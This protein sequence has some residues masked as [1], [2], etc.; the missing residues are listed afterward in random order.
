MIERLKSAIMND[1]VF[2]TFLNPQ[3][4]ITC[5]TPSLS[6]IPILLLLFFQCSLLHPQLAFNQNLRL[7]RLILTPINFWSSLKISIDYCFKPL[8][9]S[10][11]F[12]FFFSCFGIHLSLKSLEWGLADDHQLK[13]IHQIRHEFDLDDDDSKKLK[14]N[15]DADES[16]END[17]KSSDQLTLESWYIWTVDQ[18][19]SARGFQYGWGSHVQPNTRSAMEVFKRLV[20][21]HIVH[22]AVVAYS[23]YIRDIGSI[24]KVLDSIGL[25]NHLVFRILTDSISTFAF[26][27]Y[28]VSITDISY[29][30]YTL[31]A[32]LIS[33]FNQ[34]LP[35]WIKTSYNLKLFLPLYNSPHLTNSLNDLWSLHWHQLF[36]RSF[37]FIGGIQFSKLFKFLGFNK[38]LQK[39]AGLLGCFL[40]SGIM[41]ELA[42]HFV[43]RSPHSNPHYFFNS[44]GF[45][46]SLLYFMLQP[47]KQV[48]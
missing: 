10:G 31:L 28:I 19:L 12:N 44:S 27:L 43:A 22:V 15:D 17:K 1:S 9:Q 7:I 46:G 42:I 20:K 40:V 3:Q 38:Q 37:I 32:Y 24:S 25:P 36:R 47:S 39:I 34:S 8:D 35:N 2:Q 13:K 45:P 5:Q 21:V 41:H 14:K 33:S 16:I 26:G 4:P 11:I 18:F 6:I 48:T 30:Y 29:N 23:V